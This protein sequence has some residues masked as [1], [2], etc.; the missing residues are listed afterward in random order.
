MQT[1]RRRSA[2]GVKA[3]ATV[4]ESLSHHESDTKRAKRIVVSYLGD[5][6]SKSRS[7]E[8]FEP[9]GHSKVSGSQKLSSFVWISTH[10]SLRFLTR[11]PLIIFI[12]PHVCELLF[13]IHLTGPKTPLYSTKTGPVSSHVYMH[14]PHMHHM[15]WSENPPNVTRTSAFYTVQ[16][17]VVQHSTCPHR[18]QRK[19]SEDPDN[20]KQ[21]PL[22][23]RD[24]RS[25]YR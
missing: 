24:K 11:K 23:P 17:Y 8:L 3:R 6:W 21:L 19:D 20:N 14:S 12:S 25:I 22:Y 15:H 10:C 13:Y 2:S 18:E 4:T 7:R 9:Y 16:R 5:T 1:L